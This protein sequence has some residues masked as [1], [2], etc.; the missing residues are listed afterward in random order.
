MIFRGPYPNVTIPEVSLTDFIFNGTTQIKNKTALIDG[1]TGRSL[2]YGEFEDAVRRVA[3]SLSQK[4]FKKGDVFGIFST[5]C[6]EY[7]IAFHAVAMLGG[8]NT[9]VNQL[10]TAEEAAHQLSDAGA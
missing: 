1:S 8:I 2:T 5:N 7:A 9:T 4:G 3:A 10:Y 6:P